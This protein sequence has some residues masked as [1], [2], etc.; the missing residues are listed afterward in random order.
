MRQGARQA[1]LLALA[2]LGAWAAV[3]GGQSILGEVRARY[4]LDAAARTLRQDASRDGSLDPQALGDLLPTGT[5]WL[6]VP[7][8]QIDLPLAQAD[9]ADP[10]FYLTHALD[11]SASPAGTPYLDARCDVRSRHLLAFGHHLTGVGGMFSDLQPCYRQEDFDRVCGPGLVLTTTGGDGRR[12]PMR[13][14]CARRE[15]KGFL[16][17]QR[18]SWDGQEDFRTWLRDL[19]STAPAR[20]SDWEARAGAARQAMTLVTCSSNLAGRPWRTLVVFVSP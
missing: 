19:A 10:D 18:F 16:P 7:G 11:G 9:P 4:Q 12:V 20:S 15:D 5:A 13:A 1:T 17:I 14:L 3:L 8:A 6:E 2:C